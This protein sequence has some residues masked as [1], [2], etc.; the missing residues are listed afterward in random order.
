[1]MSGYA[2]SLPNELGPLVLQLTVSNA[3]A[4]VTYY[5]DVF[6]ANELYRN[7]ELGGTRIVHC[8]LLIGGVRIVVLDEFPEF[9]IVSPDA[10]AGTSVSL[11]LYIDDVDRVF[12]RAIAAGG[13]EI[14]PPQDRFWGARSGSFLDPFGHRWIISTQVDDLSPDEI[15]AR[16]KDAPLN[17]RLSASGPLR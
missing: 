7:T 10:L 17:A 5:E 6:N 9:G 8:E 13:R 4:A 2:K 3:T 14:S 15:I 16:S 12:A 11:N 1:M